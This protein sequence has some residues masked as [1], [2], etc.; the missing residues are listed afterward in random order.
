MFAVKVLGLL[1]LHLAQLFLQLSLKD[2]PNFYTPYPVA[3]YGEAWRQCLPLQNLGW[4]PG[5]PPP[6]DPDRMAIHLPFIC[7]V[8]LRPAGVV[9]LHRQYFRPMCQH[10]PLQTSRR[11]TNYTGAITAKQSM[12][13]SDKLLKGIAGLFLCHL[14]TRIAYTPY[15]WIFILNNRKVCTP[16]SVYYFLVND[17]HC[18]VVSL[19]LK[20]VIISDGFR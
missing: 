6:P 3:F 15:V 9:T 16:V 13:T 14:L 1:H 18:F 11:L 19:F 20:H 5:C 12:L 10:K 17:C 7:M 2:V 8:R 4:P